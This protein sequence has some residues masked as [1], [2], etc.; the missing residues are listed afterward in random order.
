MGLVE[1][2]EIANGSFYTGLKRSE[3]VQGNYNI[4]LF[5]KI[6]E[7][8]GKKTGCLSEKDVQLYRVQNDAENTLTALKGYTSE[9]EKKFAIK[10]ILS[11][12]PETIAEFILAYYN[13]ENKGKGVLDYKSLTLVQQL[14]TEL[15]WDEQTR[16]DVLNH[17]KTTMLK[18]ANKKG[19]EIGWFTRGNLEQ[20]NMNPGVK[21]VLNMGYVADI[22]L[23]GAAKESI[24][25]LSSGGAPEP[26]FGRE[27]YLDSD[28]IQR[29][30]D[31][32][33]DVKR[34]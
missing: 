16:N 12:N 20:S 2:N 31:D 33:S 5:D 26:S 6:D 29:Y 21:E 24:F 11:Q 25:G 18:R 1:I 4:S 13:C 3:A 32:D 17:L 28:G 14:N 7:L 19:N 9:K 10:T 34:W 22:Y 15:G 27:M 30:V 23:L 8:D